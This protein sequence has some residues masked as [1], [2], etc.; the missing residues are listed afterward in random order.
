MK[1]A[2]LW[3]ANWMTARQKTLPAAAVP[4]LVGGALAVAGDRFVGSAWLLCLGFALLIQ[5]G[6]NYHNDYEDHVRGTDDVRRIGPARAVA[7]GWVRPRSM[8]WASAVSFGLALVVGC[9]LIPFGGWWL[10]PVGL[11]CI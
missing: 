6:T 2:S 7:S 4:V 3:K 10:L 1:S 9:G 8:W 5:I 11:V